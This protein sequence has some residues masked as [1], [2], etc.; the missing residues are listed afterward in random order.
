MFKYLRSADDEI[1]MISNEITYLNKVCAEV[2]D[3]SLRAKCNALTDRLSVIKDASTTK[4]YQLQQKLACV[5]NDDA[6]AYRIIYYRYV[7]GLSW[8]Q[9]SQRT[10]SH[11]GKNISRYFKGHPEV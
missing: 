3:E 5:R 6:D 4:K 10:K 1:D 9:T 8:M 2:K 11:T 7:V